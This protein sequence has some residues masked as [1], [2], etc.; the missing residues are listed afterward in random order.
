MSDS[1]KKKAKPTKKR[2][3]TRKT[4]K[5]AR[6][7]K[8]VK[9]TPAPKPKKI[10][11]KPKRVTEKKEAPPKQVVEVERLELGPQPTAFVVVRNLDSGSSHERAAR[12]FSFGELT[13]AGVPL[14]A[15]KRVGL[16]L[17]IRRKSVVEGNVGMLKGWFKNRG[18]PSPGQ[19]AEKQAAV[20]AAPKKKQPV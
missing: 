15:A 13:S 3:P 7:K 14:N 12:G 4:A 9:P 6:T 2:A 5:V 10:A 20:V 1:G 18:Q 19:G 17:D 16:S 11:P 8:V